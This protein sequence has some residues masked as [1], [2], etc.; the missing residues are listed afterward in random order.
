MPTVDFND[1]LA[2]LDQSKTAA[3]PPHP[4]AKPSI[5]SERIETESLASASSRSATLRRVRAALAWA[6]RVGASVSRYAT[7]AEAVAG[8]EDRRTR[9]RTGKKTESAQWRAKARGGEGGPAERR[10]RRSGHE[11]AAEDEPAHPGDRRRADSEPS[12][13]RGFGAKTQPAQASGS[14][15]RRISALRL[16]KIFGKLPWGRAQAAAAS[17][18]TASDDAQAGGSR[19]T[20]SLAA[21]I[22]DERTLAEIRTAQDGG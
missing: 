1:I 5:E 11:G 19:A 8:G 12:S 16:A 10:T 6:W 2:G 4:A 7:E 3:S 20:Q 9:S 14:G 13:A 15:R 21:G 17:A 22:P 18:A